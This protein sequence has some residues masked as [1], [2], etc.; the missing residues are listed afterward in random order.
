MKYMHIHMYAKECMKYI[1]IVHVVMEQTSIPNPQ[2]KIVTRV[3]EI[4]ECPPPLVCFPFHV[5]RP[6]VIDANFVLAVS[7]TFFVFCYLYRDMLINHIFSFYYCLI[8]CY[9][10]LH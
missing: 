9:L 7:L 2:L 4:P 1:C 5:P 3:V 8:F 10:Q 6:K